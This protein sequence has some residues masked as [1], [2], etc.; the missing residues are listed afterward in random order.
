MEETNN[1]KKRIFVGGTI[2]AIV[3][4]GCV[5]GGVAFAVNAENERAAEIAAH[6][7][8]VDAFYEEKMTE[9]DAVETDV[10]TY[11][12]VSQAED[13]AEAKSID[14]VAMLEQVANLKAFMNALDKE[15]LTYFDG[16]TTPYDAL[17]STAQEEADELLVWFAEDYEKTL[18]GYEEIDVAASDKDT[19]NGYI[20]ALT[21]LKTMVGDEYAT[22]PDLWATQGEYDEYI[23]RID[24]L[25]A[26]IQA[27]VNELIAEEER[28]AVEEAARI[29]AE[30]AAAAQSYSSGNGYSG[31]SG[32]DGYDYSDNPYYDGHGSGTWAGGH[33]PGSGGVT[34][35][36]PHTGE[37]TTLD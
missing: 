19:L 13:G 2:A 35:V 30:E 21:E 14:R 32:Y 11:T 37:T 5:F 36:D 23:E 3:I 18:V 25:I 9:L 33:M 31:G 17:L 16:D 4:L 10:E 24:E 34:I 28:I 27:R 7:E 26:A 29:A 8:V 12:S 22:E 1:K 15:T 6:N 20:A